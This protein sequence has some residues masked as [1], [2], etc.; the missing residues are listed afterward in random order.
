MNNFVFR[1][2]GF[3]RSELAAWHP[4]APLDGQKLS[5]GETGIQIAANLRIGDLAHAATE[6]VSDQCPLID[7]SFA[8]EVLVARIRQRLTRPVN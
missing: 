7:N 2:D 1:L 4:N 3:G 5:R 8:L 6:S